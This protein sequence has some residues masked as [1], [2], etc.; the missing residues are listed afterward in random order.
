MVIG[1][2]VC[3]AWLLRFSF[4]SI[5]KSKIA[6]QFTHSQSVVQQL[7]RKGASKSKSENQ[8]KSSSSSSGSKLETHVTTEETDKPIS[9]YPATILGFAMVSR[10]EIGFLISSIAESKGIWQKD[11]QD[12]Q[13]SS[14]TFITVTWAIFLCTFIGPIVVGLVVRRVRSLEKQSSPRQR[15]VLGS[16]S[17]E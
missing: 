11:G 15:Q 2:L 14:D 8:K 7:V 13:G 10:G 3:G 16:W 17:L 6:S 1:K 12:V 5:W 4:L 9:L